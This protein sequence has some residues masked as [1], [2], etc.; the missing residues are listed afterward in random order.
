M[1]GGKVLGSGTYGCI[2]K[3]QLPCAGE[4]HR[5]PNY[6]SKLMSK[7]DADDEFKEITKIKKETTKVPNYNNFFVVSGI[8]KCKLGTV[9]KDDLND[10]G[11]NCLAMNRQGFTINDVKNKHKGLRLLQL[12]D[13]GKDVFHFFSK[14]F[15][16]DLFPKINSSLITLLKDGIVPLKNSN[17]IHMDIKG[18][19]VVYSKDEDVARLIDWGLTTVVKGTELPTKATG[20]PIMY[21]QPLTNTVLHLTIQEA[22][23]NIIKSKNIK[24]LIKTYNGTD[25]IT[26]LKPYVFILLRQIVFKDK[27]TIDAYVGIGHVDYIS[28]LIKECNKYDDTFKKNKPEPGHSPEFGTV[29]NIIATHATLALLHFSVKNNKMGKFDKKQFFNNVFKQ[30]CD[31]FGWLSCYID[32]FTNQK[33]PKPLRKKIYNTILKPFYLENKYSYTKFN[34]DKIAKACLALNDGY[35][36]QPKKLIIKK[37][38]VIYPKKKLII[39]TKKFPAKRVPAKKATLTRPVGKRCPN[40]TRRDKITKKCIKYTKKVNISL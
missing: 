33:A 13:G 37:K 38:I 39:K 1:Q 15:S 6:V 32:V 3:P 19:N 36:K 29:A 5:N 34:V 8:K 10:F 18:P 22:Y 20:W 26:H 16:I 21:N 27:N 11:P 14:N 9:T 12:P 28:Q 23:A 35:V 24:N 40:G 25:L 7:R 4:S 31:I 17:V 2:F 30:N